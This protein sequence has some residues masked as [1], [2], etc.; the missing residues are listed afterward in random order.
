MKTAAAFLESRRVAAMM[1]ATTEF[2]KEEGITYSAKGNK[3]STH[4]VALLVA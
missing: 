4:A 3:V 1:G 2:E